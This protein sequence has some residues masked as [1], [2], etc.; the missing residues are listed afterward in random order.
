MI[1]QK[2]LNTMKFLLKDGFGH[3][4]VNRCSVVDKNG[5]PLRTKSNKKMCNISAFTT[6]S[7][8]KNAFINDFVYE[9]A[10]WR[11][12]NIEHAFGIKDFFVN[13]E[14]NTDI[15][16]NKFS[17]AVLTT[18]TYEGKTGALVKV[19][20]IKTYIP[21]SF[22]DVVSLNNKQNGGLVSMAESA[23]EGQTKPA[24]SF[25]ADLDDLPF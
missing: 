10:I 4:E 17:G 2:D 24:A 14:F 21:L 19:S 6:D 18:D 8:G 9:D 16:Q 7:Q 5:H 15:L 3:I 22:F 20:K 12:K 23:I 11:I 25:D 13:G 1:N